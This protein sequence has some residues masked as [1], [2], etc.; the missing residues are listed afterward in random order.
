MRRMLF[1]LAGAM[2]LSALVYYAGARHGAVTL[3][4]WL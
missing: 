3:A 1:E 2:T 4:Q